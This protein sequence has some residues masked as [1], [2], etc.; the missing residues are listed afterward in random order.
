MTDIIKTYQSLEEEFPMEEMRRLYLAKF[1]ETVDGRLR[2]Y[3]NWEISNKGALTTAEGEVLPFISMY[4]WF[5]FT[6]GTGRRATT[7]GVSCYVDLT[8]YDLLGKTHFM[9]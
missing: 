1:G 3:G 2:L 9:P 8:I 6:E 7:Y 4:Y 5:T